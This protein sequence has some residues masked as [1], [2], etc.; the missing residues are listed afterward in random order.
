LQAFGVQLNT[1]LMRST[2]EPGNDSLSSL[3]SPTRPM[4]GQAKYVVNAGLTYSSSRL[5]ATVLY[6]VVGPRI[7]EAAIQPLPDVVEQARQV[8]DVSLQTPVGPHATFKL[9]AK[10]LLDAPYRVMQ[11][12]IERHYF[13][14]G[15]VYTLGISW[16]P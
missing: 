2:I 16:T 6:N 4:V 14:T 8:V 15:R 12:A 7:R 9:D 13:R 5:N 1:T 10:N 3:T 11:G